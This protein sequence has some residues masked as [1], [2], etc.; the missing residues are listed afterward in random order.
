MS[1]QSIITADGLKVERYNIIG[2]NILIYTA[3]EPVVWDKARG[4]S[5]YSLTCDNGTWWG[6]IGTGP[7]PAE[8]EALPPWSRERSDAFNR[9]FAAECDRAYAAILTAFPEAFIGTMRNGEIT[10]VRS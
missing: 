7:L 5:H 6:H 8:I 4:P 9:W 1:A 2:T 10:V 3:S